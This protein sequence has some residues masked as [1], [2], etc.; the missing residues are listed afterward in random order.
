[1]LAKVFAE[2]KPRYVEATFDTSA[3]TFRHTEYG[4]YKATRLAMADGLRS[5]FPKVFELLETL[6][7][8]IVRVDGYE[9]DDLLGTLAKQAVEQGREV[10]I[11]T[12]DTD[13]LQLV[14][15]IVGVLPLGVV[16]MD[17]EGEPRPASGG[18]PFQHLEVA[19]GVAEGG[20]RPPSDPALDAHRLALLVGL[21]VDRIE[22]FLPL[23]GSQGALRNQDG[24]ARHADIKAQT[25]E[26]AG[27]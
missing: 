4:D 14:G 13:V 27:R 21:R 12:G 2:L 9:A 1:M 19:V 20:D 22:E 3:Q 8:P 23:I 26:Q 6:A 15:P 11:L 7:V 16:V 5:Q 25:H 17:E 18:G 10:V 24:F